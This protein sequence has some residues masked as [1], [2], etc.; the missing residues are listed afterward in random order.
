MTDIKSLFRDL[1]FEGPSKEERRKRLARNM[2][3]ELRERRRAME[4]SLRDLGY[5]DPTDKERREQLARSMA[6]K[7]LPVGGSKG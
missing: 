6:L 3:L 2:A 5:E 7:N 1:G 4:A